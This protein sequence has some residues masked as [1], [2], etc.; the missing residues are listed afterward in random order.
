MRERPQ[1]PYSVGSSPTRGTCHRRST[2][3]TENVSGTRDHGFM[4]PQATVDRARQLS[5]QGLID[6]VVA[7]SVGVSIGAVQKWRTGIRRAP[8]T[9]RKSGCPRCDGQPLDEPA[10]SYLFGLYLGDGCISVGGDRAK[11]VWKLSIFCDDAWPG[12]FQEC[13]QAMRTV[14]PDNKVSRV[15]RQGCTEVKSYS[16]HWP[17]LFPQHGPGKKHTRRPTSSGSAGRRWTGW[18]WSGGSRSRTRSRSRSGTRWRGWTSSSG[19]S[20]DLHLWAATWGMQEAR[21]RSENRFCAFAFSC[22]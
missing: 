11:A 8:G 5:Q 19:R 20:T 18:G 16:R 15:L 7:Q 4:H 14:R 3:L 17:C 6:R 21:V 1:T 13:A 2:A 12:L 10:Y 9:E 22:C